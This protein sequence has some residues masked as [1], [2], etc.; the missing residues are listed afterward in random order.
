M[1]YGLS[2]LAVSVQAVR[3]HGFPIILLHDGPAPSIESLPT[4]LQG[5]EVLAFDN[6]ALG[7]KIVAK[8]NIPAREVFADYRRDIHAMPKL[9]VWFEVG[10]VDAAWKGVLLGVCDGEID[11]HGVGPRG[12][13]PE[14]AL[15]EYPLQGMKLNIGEKDY[16]AWAVHNQLD[17]DSS[18]FV[19][20]QGDPASLLFGPLA[21]GDEAEVFMMNVK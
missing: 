9:G 6:P 5:A 15:L 16:T 3:G 11:A 12:T 14:K 13:R 21:E 17:A 4:P 1:R 2:L 8:A 10:P 7:A 19:R 18:Y 20:I